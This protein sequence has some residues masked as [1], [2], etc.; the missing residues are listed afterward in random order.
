MEFLR[1]RPVKLLCS[2]N[3]LPHNMR[4]Q[5]QITFNIHTT[6]GFSELCTYYHRHPDSLTIR[7]SEL[8]QRSP[9]FK[10][11]DDTTLISEGGFRVSKGCLFMKF[12]KFSA[13]NTDS[14]E[15]ADVSYLL[16][17]LFCLSVSVIDRWFKLYETKGASLYWPAHS[18]DSL[19]TGRGSLLLSS[20]WNCED[21]KQLCRE[22]VESKGRGKKCNEDLCQELFQHI[23]KTQTS[24]CFLLLLK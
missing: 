21:M 8:Q 10:V 14:L 11:Q 24:C 9:S 18:C 22:L 7:W 4:H 3:G 1:F 12:I 17:Y 2:C 6:P 16:H 13:T 15:C 5:L 20:I 19:N 23:F